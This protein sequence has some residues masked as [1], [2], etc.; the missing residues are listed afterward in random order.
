MRRRGRFAYKR[1]RQATLTL[2]GAVHARAIPGGD[3][4]SG[5]DGRFARTCGRRAEA[6]DKP[7][8]CAICSTGGR[9]LP[10]ATIPP[11]AAQLRLPKRFGADLRIGNADLE[12]H[13]PL[14]AG[15]PSP[16]QQH[17]ALRILLSHGGGKEAGRDRVAYLGRRLRPG[18][19]LLPRAGESGRGG[20][21]FEDALLRRAASKRL[22]HADD[23][24]GSRGDGARHDA[25]RVGYSPGRQ[26]AGRAAG[27]RPRTIGHHGHQPGRHHRR[28]GGGH[29]TAIFQGLLAA[30]R[31]RHGGSGLDLDRNGP[32][33]QALGRVGAHEG[34]I[35]RRLEGHRPG[36][37]CP[38]P[39]RS[40]SPDAQRQPGRSNT[41][42]LYPR[43]SR[44]FG[45]PEIVWW[46]AG[47]YSAIRYLGSGLARVVEFFEPAPTIQSTAK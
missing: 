44:A 43:A 19:N 47:H 25:G 27:C 42:G 24:D 34:R 30:G 15:D 17:G 35:V 32:L 37:V 28:I 6:D 29:G 5:H 45:E 16:E 41:S 46:N 2:E 38:A 3:L 40:Q 39:S 8:R 20:A 4:A 23:F 36:D 18:A 31:R 22:A 9:G 10:A 14:A 7:E 1:Q 13:L 11:G 21:F 33:A 26:L 12:G